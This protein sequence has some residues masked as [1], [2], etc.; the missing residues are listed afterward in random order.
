MCT[1][2]LVDW[3]RLGEVYRDGSRVV[4][5][6]NT[7][8][9][10]TWR[11]LGIG[12]RLVMD[13]KDLAGLTL[14]PCLFVDGKAMKNREVL[15]HER[16][17]LAQQAEAGVLPFYVFYAT[18]ML[19]RLL[20]GDGENSYVNL[21][22]ER[23]AYEHEDEGS[24]LKSREAFAWWPLLLV[25]ASDEISI[26]Q[27]PAPRK[28]LITMAVMTV[29]WPLTFLL[30]LLA[31][32][33]AA[34]VLA[35]RLFLAAITEVD[36]DAE[37]ADRTRAFRRV[38]A[39]ALAYQTHITRRTLR[40]AA[41][42]P[43]RLRFRLPGLPLA[44]LLFDDANA[45]ADAAAALQLA[46]ALALLVWPRAGALCSAAAVAYL[47]LAEQSLYQNHYWLVLNVLLCF[48]AAARRPRAL[49]SLLRFDAGAVRLRCLRQAERGLGAAMGARCA[50]VRARPPADVIA[51]AGAA[52]GVAALRARALHRR[53]R[54]RRCGAA[55]ARAAVGGVALA[56]RRLRG[57]TRLP[58]V[59][60][61]PL[62]HRHLSGGD[63]GR[64]RAVAA[65][66]TDA[67]TARGARA[68]GEARA[69]ERRHAAP[70]PLAGA[71]APL[72]AG[73]PAAARRLHRL[74][75][76]VRGAAPRVAAPTRRPLPRPPAVDPGGLSL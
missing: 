1:L 62:P 7:A 54:H 21:S 72:G 9:S 14:W 4:E 43:S 75:R 20:T 16:I 70:R 2:P 46:G 12:L 56:C 42:S 29:C 59:Q 28:F 48:A 71:A 52:A 15:W 38:L 53:H 45:T 65:A 10:W 25:D 5:D 17:H 13:V 57:R 66:A 63:G 67:G 18:E 69:G 60:R 36:D 23:E 51:R 68:V 39:A 30:G 58:R 76:G 40:L 74:R 50:L 64:P 22:F 41:L 33:V 49:L 44:P 31:L 8:G 47:L 27:A 73:R 61:P 35:S 37:A 6:V 32:A 24:Y 34:A 19:A 3:L 26:L 11:V 55:A